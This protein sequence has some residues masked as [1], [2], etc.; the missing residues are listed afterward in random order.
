[1]LKNQKYFECLTSRCLFFNNNRVFQG[2]TT[3]AYDFADMDGSMVVTAVRAVSILDNVGLI[4][5][6]RVVT[7]SCTGDSASF[8]PNGTTGA[9]VYKT[10]ICVRFD[11]DV[12]TN[13][14]RDYVNAWHTGQ[15]W[16]AVRNEMVG[17]IRNS[18]PD[19]INQTDGGVKEGNQCTDDD[20]QAV[21][22]WVASF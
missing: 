9:D 6:K 15:T 8:C 5:F 7:H 2:T 20:M 1:M 22:P 11:H 13:D 17:F 14:Y 10:G 21:T 4:L 16:I 3:T 19:A 18:L 12:F